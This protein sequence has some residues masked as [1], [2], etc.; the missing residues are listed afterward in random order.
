VGATLAVSVPGYEEMLLSSGMAD[1]EKNIPMRPDHL[2]KIASNTKTFVA[3]VLLQLAQE[4]RVDIDGT[5]DRWF[6]DLPNAKFITV[7]QV[8]TQQ[9]GVPDFFDY[10]LDN[11]P[12]PESVWSTQDIVDHAYAT[13][14]V[15]PPGAYDYSNTNYVLLALIIE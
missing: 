5:I 10:S 11:N 13:N 8:M 2:L 9:S 4:G 14:P 12:P 7:R 3:G 15:K 6:P 1:L